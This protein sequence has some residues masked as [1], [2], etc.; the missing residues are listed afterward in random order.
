MLIT[1]LIIISLLN[2]SVSGA[3][4]FTDSQC[5]RGLKCC[6]FGLGASDG[7][8]KDGYCSVC[9]SDAD[10]KKHGS[11]SK[12]FITGQFVRKVTVVDNL[13]CSCQDKEEAEAEA[14]AEAESGTKTRKIPD[15]KTKNSI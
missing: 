13:G 3:Q 4:C 1:A 11:K 14:E 6:R 5:T 10:C 7:K 15:K 12:C 8:T 9:N 2:G